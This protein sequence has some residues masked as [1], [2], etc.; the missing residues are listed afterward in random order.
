MLRRRRTKQRVRR[1]RRVPIA[2]PSN[3]KHDERTP[4]VSRDCDRTATARKSDIGRP[5]VAVRALRIVRFAAKRRSVF[6]S[7]WFPVGAVFFVNVGRTRVRFRGEG[8]TRFG[9]GLADG[10]PVA[11]NRKPKNVIRISRPVRSR[12]TAGN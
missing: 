7:E 12:I 9:W 11:R 10:R 2:L 5:V 3:A 8:C 4:Y 1:A 6:N